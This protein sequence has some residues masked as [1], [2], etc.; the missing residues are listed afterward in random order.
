MLREQ[1][2]GAAY[3]SRCSPFKI[4]KSQTGR[5]CADP[6]NPLRYAGVPVP[7]LRAC[8]YAAVRRSAKFITLRRRTRSLTGT[9]RYADPQ[10]TLRYAGLPAL[11]ELGCGEYIAIS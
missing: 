6:P 7:K 11:V 9:P 1:V 2:Y 5:R 8:R 10:N 3:P 4:L